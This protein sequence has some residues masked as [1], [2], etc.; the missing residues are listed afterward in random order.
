MVHDTAESFIRYSAQESYVDTDGWVR[1]CSVNGIARA[2][3]ESSDVLGLRDSHCPLPPP[4]PP[5]R[6]PFQQ[7]TPPPYTPPL[8]LKLWGAILLFPHSLWGAILLLP[9]ITAS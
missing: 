5:L 8:K 3:H 2:V 7:H 1:P 4:R 9:T 6:A